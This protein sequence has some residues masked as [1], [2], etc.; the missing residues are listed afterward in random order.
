[1]RNKKMKYED[2]LSLMKSAL[3]AEI[4]KR[5][6]NLEV[7]IDQKMSNGAMRGGLRITSQENNFTTFWRVEEGFDKDPIYAIRLGM[8][9]GMLVE[10]ILN[11]FEEGLQSVDE[12]ERL[13]KDYAHVKDAILPILYPQEFLENLEEECMHYSFF[14]L[15]ICYFIVGEKLGIPI[16]NMLITKEMIGAWG[17]TEEELKKKALENQK[18]CTVLQSMD[19]VMEM[20]EKN[21]VSYEVNRSEDTKEMYMLKY[22]LKFMGAAAMLNRDMLN[23]HANRIK[24]KRL[25]L[26]PSS[27]HECLVMDGKDIDIEKLRC[28]IAIENISM[29]KEEDILSFSP[30]YYDVEEGYGIYS[31]NE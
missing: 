21:G 4:E 30:Y 8:N 18:S 14:D 26:I 31:E 17:I 10:D 1:M 28:V 29:L 25:V 7:S 9:M 11:A 2:F 23:E 15:E 24:T 22:D 16:G 27:V 3:E 19:E 6:C 13:L 5:G 20:M 12:V